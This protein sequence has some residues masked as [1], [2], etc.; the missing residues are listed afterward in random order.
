[1]TDQ[2]H[3]VDY[4][5][6]KWWVG[7]VEDRDDPLKIGRVRV[8]I[9]GYHPEDKGQVPTEALPWAITI[10]PI[11]DAGQKGVG[12][13]PVGLQINSQVTGFF[14]DGENAQMPAVTGVLVG[15]PNGRPDTNRLTRG[16]E[17]SQTIVEQK[18][19]NRL[20]SLPMSLTSSLGAIA[21]IQ[22]NI[23]AQVSGV[24]NQM[25]RI[26]K[27]G[28]QLK[29]AK[30]AIPGIQIPDISA[31][32]QGVNGQ[33]QG[34]RGNIQSL[35]RAA[36]GIQ[37]ASNNVVNVITENITQV[38]QEAQNLNSAAAAVGGVENDIRSQI[39]R[40]QNGM[41]DATSQVDNQVEALTEIPAS[42]IASIDSAVGTADRAVNSVM[43]GVNGITGSISGTL[44]Q[45]KSLDKLASL[46]PGIG[47]P[48]VSNLIGSFNQLTNAMDSIANLSGA[49]NSL[50]QIVGIIGK[51]KGLSMVIPNAASI[52]GAITAL[53]AGPLSN[54][55]SQPLS[56]ANP[57]Y[58]YNKVYET[59]GGHVE[60]FDDTPGS[61]RYQR[62]HPS[63]SFI[64][65]HPDG[66]RSEKIIKDRYTV[67][68]GDD[69]IHVQGNVKVNIIGNAD[70]VVVGNATTQVNGNKTDIVKGDYSLMVGGNMSTAVGLMR[71]DGAGVMH[72]VT[73]PQIWLN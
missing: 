28:D 60:E 37:S 48:D 24:T 72:K 39:L 54:M 32:I 18:N 4:G 36:D 5:N 50:N 11:T 42:A 3:G 19:R 26:K 55:F 70:V 66:T 62:Y 33:F 30:L 45:L 53:Q 44:D 65:D 63:G 57:E 73:A 43:N 8:R 41:A 35:N 10:N 12:M 51:I 14:L 56:P 67:I 71:T 38:Y 27:M 29:N 52:M 23:Q 34:L 31:A 7:T 1:M 47:I 16:E 21:S 40:L 13:A 49:M 46:N 61:E 69:S 25:A 58:P 6:Y 2:I 9:N 15:A 17:I 59:E 22:Q 64:E 68:M 20:I